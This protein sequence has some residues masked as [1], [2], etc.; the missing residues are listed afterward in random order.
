MNPFSSRRQDR[1]TLSSA[2]KVKRHAKEK[3]FTQMKALSGGKHANAFLCQP[4]AGIPFVLKLLPLK[5]KDHVNL[6]QLWIDY[7]DHNMVSPQEFPAAVVEYLLYA[8]CNAWSD[9]GS[10]LQAPYCYCVFHFTGA[11]L[12]SYIEFA[13]QEELV[14]RSFWKE[15]KTKHNNPRFICLCLEYTPLTSVRVWNARLWQQIAKLDSKMLKELSVPTWSLT[16]P[17]RQPQSWNLVW[18]SIFWQV[19]FGITTMQTRLAGFRHFDLHFGN[20]LLRSM[21][22][23]ELYLKYE[24]EG[25][26]YYVPCVFLVQIFDFDFASS[27]TYL[28]AKVHQNQPGLKLQHGI[29]PD[30]T[31]AYDSHLFFTGLQQYSKFDT[32]I[33]DFLNVVVPSGYRM[34]EKF[35]CK[36]KPTSEKPKP[37]SYRLQ[38]G[39]HPVPHPCDL[40]SHPIFDCFQHKPLSGQILY[41]LTVLEPSGP[42]A[43][44]MQLISSVEKGACP[45]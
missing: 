44:P 16:G 45:V 39:N 32:E 13:D 23:Q 5:D 31:P 33:K 29:C 35:V 10:F 25:K 28:N 21:G 19:L 2:L 9:T 3:M 27:G 6:R 14:T 43:S 15:W 7:Q 26:M 37:M 4:V 34:N 20:V 11:D 41:H 38:Y 12:E 17:P 1:G 24:W 18:K 22:D 8:R 42:C 40:L 30:T 36:V